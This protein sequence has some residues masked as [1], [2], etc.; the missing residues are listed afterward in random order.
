MRLVMGSTARAVLAAVV[1]LAVV[2]AGASAASTMSLSVEP[3]VPAEGKSFQ[4][5]A[6]GTRESPSGRSR[7]GTFL[8]VATEPCGSTDTFEKAKDEG[9]EV[10]AFSLEPNG[11]YD[12][13]GVFG[14]AVLASYSVDSG[15]I[16]GKYRI[17]GYVTDDKSA[18]SISVPPLV[19]A[20]LDFTVG[21]TCPSATAK[22]TRVEGRLKGAKKKLSR[23]KKKLSK[24]KKAG[25]RV[26]AKKAQKKVRQIKRKLKSAKE[27]RTVL[28]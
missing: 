4:V 22:V 18:S 5:I 20:R 19:A 6:Q 27:D 25:A 28:C 7:G 23:A 2:P 26:K 1:V 9:R 12:F 13:R 11:P 3:A 16:T 15:L 17:C 10:G 8:N 24:S 21:G 14:G